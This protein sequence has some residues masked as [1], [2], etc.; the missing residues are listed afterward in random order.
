ML[1]SADI[2]KSGVEPSKEINIDAPY[3]LDIYPSSG[4]IV[5]Q[6]E[7]KSLPLIDIDTFMLIA[8]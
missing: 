4:Y 6:K 8:T 3:D 7:M 5:Y 2:L 1:I